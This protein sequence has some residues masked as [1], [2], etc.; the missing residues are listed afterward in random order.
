MIEM[1][2]QIGRTLASKQV[3]HQNRTEKAISLTTKKVEVEMRKRE[4]HSNKIELK[5]Q[6]ETEESEKYIFYDFN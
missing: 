3:K 4:S 6:I 1:I 5:L 2:L